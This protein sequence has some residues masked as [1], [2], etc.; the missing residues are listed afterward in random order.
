MSTKKICTLGID[1]NR[2]SQLARAAALSVPALPEI[3][4]QGV[5][6]QSFCVKIFCFYS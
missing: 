1:E 5:A 6:K 3:T 2:E 4:A